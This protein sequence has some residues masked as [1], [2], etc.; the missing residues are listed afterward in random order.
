MRYIVHTKFNDKAIG[1][2]IILPQ[3]TICYSK[4]NMIQYN[5]KDICVIG[6]ENARRFF[7]IDE[8]GM[9][10]IRGRLIQNIQKTLKCHDDNY[11]NRWSK[12]WNDKTCIRYRQKEH[13]YWYWNDDFF[14]TD[15]DTLRYIFNLVNLESQTNKEV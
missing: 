2:N 8:D 13:D 14:T 11:H 3:M 7:A 15:I 9:G 12:V 5:G 4:D 1:G 10:M 6:S